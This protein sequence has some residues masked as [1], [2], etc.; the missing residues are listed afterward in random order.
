[1][2]IYIYIY[3]YITC[4][5]VGIQRSSRHFTTVS[6]IH[7]NDEPPSHLTTFPQWLLFSKNLSFHRGKILT[8]LLLLVFSCSYPDSETSENLFTN[9]VLATSYFFTFFLSLLQLRFFPTCHNSMPA[10]IVSP[11]S[12]S[13]FN[14]S[15]CAVINRNRQELSWIPDT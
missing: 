15:S 4:E 6:L 13:S 10:V 12:E 8:L 5:N 9:M 1:M 2:C 3:I 14:S 11:T 7:Q